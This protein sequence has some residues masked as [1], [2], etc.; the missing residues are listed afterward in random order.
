MSF[1]CIPKGSLL[2][3]TG[4]NSKFQ[5]TNSAVTDAALAR[6]FKVRGVTR[7]ISKAAPFQKLLDDKYGKGTLSWSKSRIWPPWMPLMEF[8]KVCVAGVLHLATDSSLSTSYDVVVRS[9]VQATMGLMKAAAKVSSVKSFVLTSS[10]ITI[11]NPDYE[12]PEIS[13]KLDQWGEHFVDAA[14]QT[15]DDHPMKGVL[16][17]AASKVQGEHTAWD[18]YISAR[19]SYAFN[20]VLP[21][22]VI[23][24]VFNPTPGVYSTHTFLNALFFS[25][26]EPA[27]LKFVQPASLA[28]DVRDVASI[29]LAALLSLSTEGK[30][31]WAAVHRFEINDI[32]AI[33]REEF[34]ER[35]FVEDF[36]LPPQPKITL[37]L[38]PSE[39]LVK[40]FEGRS[41]L[42]LK[43][44]AIANVQD[45]L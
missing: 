45:V 34:P 8:W 41:W 9:V 36:K 23:S 40:A 35:K 26:P 32:L 10:R 16:I 17:Y 43:E 39:E 4:L 29:H 5:S 22:L 28:M 33:W 25:E 13:P 24:P 15:P 7:S 31:I 12:Q 14:K 42:S 27:I 2:L 44:S 18:Y 37:E 19:P 30:R 6:G 3:V 20:V 21:D 38:A 1:D 11:F